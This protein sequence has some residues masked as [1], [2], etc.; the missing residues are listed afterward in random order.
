M[1]DT[2]PNDFGPGSTLTPS[3]GIETVA[4]WDLTT[5]EDKLSLLIANVYFTGSFCSKQIT[6]LCL[7]PHDLHINEDSRI[8]PKCGI[9]SFFVVDFAVP[10]PLQT[11]QSII[12]FVNKSSLNLS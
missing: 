12:V 6:S 7:Y 11:G 8:S 10:F 2:Y 4:D 3:S 1:L 9:F 5:L